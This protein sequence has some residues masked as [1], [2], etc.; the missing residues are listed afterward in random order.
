MARNTSWHR[1]FLSLQSL[2]RRKLKVI[3]IYI[4]TPMDLATQRAAH[5]VTC[6]LTVTHMPMLTLSL[7]QAQNL[8]A[9]LNWTLILTVTQKIWTSR[10]L[11]IS[12]STICLH[13]SKPKL[14]SRS[15]STRRCLLRWLS[16]SQRSKVATLMPWRHTWHRWGQTLM[17]VRNKPWHR[18][19]LSTRTSL[20]WQTSW[21]SW[22]T[23]T[24]IRS[25]P[26]WPNP[27]SLMM[28]SSSP[29]LMK[30]RTC[31]LRLPHSCHN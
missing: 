17:T 3:H 16:T 29:R 2:L 27:K 21:P 6:T 22:R 10:K 20:R 23:R 11:T 18:R 26:I 7:T 1:H 13:R 14:T 9:I 28:S 24:L 19:Q 5:T 4:V 25:R 12:I 31:F 15:A 30:M 8:T